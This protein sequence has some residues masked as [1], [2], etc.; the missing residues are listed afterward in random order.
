MTKLTYT[1]Y[2]G[3]GLDDLSAAFWL[4][5]QCVYTIQLCFYQYLSFLTKFDC[6]KI[7]L[8]KIFWVLPWWPF[9]SLLRFCMSLLKSYQPSFWPH[10]FWFLESNY[11]FYQS[12][13]SLINILMKQIFD[14]YLAFYG[15]LWPLL[16]TTGFKDMSTTWK[17]LKD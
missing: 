8:Y 15:L 14:L 12:L 13:L 5:L 10:L 9:C 2:F 11:C 4:L 16:N 17:L 7:N 1:R 6:N 3:F